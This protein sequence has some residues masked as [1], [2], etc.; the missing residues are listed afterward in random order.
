MSDMKEETKFQ[1]KCEKYVS[2]EVYLRQNAA[3][4]AFQKNEDEDFFERVENMYRETCPHCGEDVD[5]S[6]CEVEDAGKFDFEYKCTECNVEF[7][8]PNSEPNEIYEWWAVSP[9]LAQRLLD[10]GEPMYD[11]DDCKIWGR[12]TTGQSI[13]LDGVI[14]QIVRETEADGF[15]V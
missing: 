15:T 14:R 7:G 12:C 2:Q 10:K 9:R 8:N 11:G 3:C 13:L 5:I 1:R 4:E 6:R